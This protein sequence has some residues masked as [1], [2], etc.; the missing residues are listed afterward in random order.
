MKDVTTI[1]PYDEAA[2]GEATIGPVIT[3]AD[4]CVDSVVVIDDKSADATATVTHGHDR[5]DISLF[6]LIT[7]A[8]DDIG[9]MFNKLLHLNEA[10]SL[11]ENTIEESVTEHE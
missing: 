6:V 8:F 10:T 11:F 9:K 3:E 1:T 7:H 2:I 4:T 5:K